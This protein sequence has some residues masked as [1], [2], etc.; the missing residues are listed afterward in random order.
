MF[1]EIKI[2][3]TL[4]AEQEADMPRTSEAELQAIEAHSEAI[5]RIVE[6]P[7]DLLKAD[8]ETLGYIIEIED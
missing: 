6:A 3:I 1:Q 2:K 7:L 8:L 4:N 5:D